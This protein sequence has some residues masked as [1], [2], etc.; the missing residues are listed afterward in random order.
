MPLDPVWIEALYP[1][2]IEA[3]VVSESVLPAIWST[4]SGVTREIGAKWLREKRTALLDVPSVVVPD[5]RNCL[6]NPAH[7]DSSKI[8]VHEHR[9]SIDKRLAQIVRY[10]FSY[11]EEARFVGIES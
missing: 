11:R 7:P 9:F 4:D 1:S 6:L 5:A 8:T 2:S 3:D 10:A